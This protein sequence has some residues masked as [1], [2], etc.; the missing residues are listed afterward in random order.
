VRVTV[1]GDQINYPDDMSTKTS[2]LATVKILLHSKI[3]TPNARFMTM[4]IKDFYLNT[5]MDI[6]E[7]IKVPLSLFPPAIQDHYRLPSLAKDR[8]IYAEI[9]KCGCPNPAN[10]QTM[11]SSPTWQA[12]VTSKA[13]SLP[14]FSPIPH[15]PSLS[16]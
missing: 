9:Q 3:S 11:T 15:D 6:Y 14:V 1:G 8:F 2:D 13:L 5:P 16:A 7:Y 4:D 10:Y 12:T